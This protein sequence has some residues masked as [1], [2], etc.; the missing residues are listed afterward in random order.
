M[1]HP[2]HTFSWKAIARLITTITALY[3]I[4]RLYSV[5]LMILVGV[6]LAAAFYPL[7]LKL[8]KRRVSNT[9][10]AIL[11]VFALISPVFLILFTILPG[12]VQQFPEIVKTVEH[13]INQSTFLPPAVR[14]IEISQYLNDA[15]SYVLRSTS[16]ITNSV[17]AFF[18]VIFL[19]LYF[20]I[21]SKRLNELVLSLIPDENKAKARQLAEDLT[22]IN[23]QYIRG[24]LLISLVC[25]I[26]IA[27]GLIAIGVP[28]AAPLALFAALVDMLPQI[29]AVLG[30]IP[31]IIIAF[32]VSP[33]AGV[34]TLLLFIVYQQIENN[35]LSPNIYNKALNLSPALSFIA[36]LIGGSLGGIVGAFISLPIAAS[37]P[38]I[39]SFIQEHP[40]KSDE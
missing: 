11:V 19:T 10:S 16:A 20:L 26:T 27:I 17:A 32:S 38:T 1:K 9:L 33:T 3:L 37:I 23:G 8:E 7:V 28:Y 36:V 31:A 34:L 14:N 15:A 30:A 25:G 12:I 13:A 18:T 4:W 39:V 35:I 5:L 2:E 24:N 29:G 6:M 40:I 22:K 21:D